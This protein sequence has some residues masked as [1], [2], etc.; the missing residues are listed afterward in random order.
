MGPVLS[1]LD[2]FLWYVIRSTVLSI[3]RPFILGLPISTLWCEIYCTSTETDLRQA[4]GHS[5]Y[6]SQIQAQSI[7][8]PDLECCHYVDVSGAFTFHW[9]LS[10]HQVASET[11]TERRTLRAHA[12]FMS[13]GDRGFKGEFFPA[14]MEARQ[15]DEL[16]SFGSRWQLITLCLF[17]QMRAN[18]RFVEPLLLWKKKRG[19]FYLYVKTSRKRTNILE[20][21]FSSTWC[22]CIPFNG[23]VLS[24]I[25]R[26]LQ[27][28]RTCSMVRIH[29]V[30]RMRRVAV[31]RQQM[32]YLS[33]FYCIGFNQEFCTWVHTTYP[34][35][36]FSSCTDTLPNCI[37]YDELF[38]CH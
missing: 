29:S 6:G 7:G 11:D 20:L 34:Y 27:M 21:H 23:T 35:L 4:I 30:A 28:S 17:L 31:Q 16:H 14:L 13:Q 26:S 32:I 38:K 22:S 12:L 19:F 9:P 37:W 10:Y 8:Q 25:P 15:R 3:S 33:P 2:T 18:V 5:R 1:F 24:K 36:G